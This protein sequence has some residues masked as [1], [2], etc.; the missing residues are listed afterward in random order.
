MR[1]VRFVEWLGMLRSA[2]PETLSIRRSSLLATGVV[3]RRTRLPEHR[4]GPEDRIQDLARRE[5]C[6][7][8]EKKNPHRKF[9]SRSFN[10]K[11]VD[12]FVV[13]L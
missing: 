13:V 2:V 5:L 1:K 7:P 4:S 3:L 11:I 10:L 6:P 8:A 9:P 12:I